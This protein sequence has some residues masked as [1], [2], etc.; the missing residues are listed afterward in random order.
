MLMFSL[1]ILIVRLGGFQLVMS[2]ALHGLYRLRD[3][4]FWHSHLLGDGLCCKLSAT[5]DDRPCVLAGSWGTLVYDCVA[6]VRSAEFFI[7][8]LKGVDTNHL[9]RLLESVL[10]RRIT[11][12]WQLMHSAH[13]SKRC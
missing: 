8:A 13:M 9:K 10:N 11:L 2:Y 1:N 12:W 5:H 3:G 7:Y 4:G 6:D